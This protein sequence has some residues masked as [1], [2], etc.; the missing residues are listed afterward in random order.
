[1]KTNRT[2]APRLAVLVLGMLLAGT[3]NAQTSRDSVEAVVNQL[4]AAMKNADSVTVMQNFWPAAIMQTMTTTKSGSDTVRTEMV[5]RF[6]SAVGRQKPG[7]FDERIVFGEVLIDANIA[8]AWTPYQFYLN[9]N[10]SHCGVNCF[11][12]SRIDG[13]WKINHIIDT[14]RKTGC[15]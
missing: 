8:V 14:R 13:I 15:L 10:F 12:L 7:A 5:S 3:S 6:A 4:F 1:M 2:K 9:G 11:Q